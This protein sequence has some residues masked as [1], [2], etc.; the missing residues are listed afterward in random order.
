MKCPKCK[1]G[2]LIKYPYEEDVYVCNN[3]KCLNVVEM[4][5]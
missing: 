3:K 1:I 4:R 2:E 5:I